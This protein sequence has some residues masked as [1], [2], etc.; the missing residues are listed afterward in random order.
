MKLRNWI[1]LGFY[2]SDGTHYCVLARRGR[3]GMLHFR[4]RMVSGNFHVSAF[5]PPKIDVQKQWEL[6]T[7]EA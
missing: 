4:C 7:K 6:L 2:T 3:W 5:V 1:V